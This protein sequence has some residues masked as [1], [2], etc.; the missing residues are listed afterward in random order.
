MA[1]TKRRP[2]FGYVFCDKKLSRKDEVLRIS[3]ATGHHRRWVAMTLLEFWGWV[4]DNF[5]SGVL[6]RHSVAT[7]SLSVD[8]TDA[9][10]WQ[11]VIDVGWL[12]VTPEG[13]EVPGCDVWLGCMAKKRHQDALR[14][15]YKRQG[16]TE[17]GDSGTTKSGLGRDVGAAKKRRRPSK[18]K[19]KRE[20]VSSIEETSLERSRNELWDA[21]CA[22]FGLDPRT[23]G[24]RS[25]V[26]KV[27]RDLG[28][29]GALPAEVAV[30]L[31][32]YRRE[33]PS[34]ADT[35]EA[36]LKHWDRFAKEP[37]DGRRPSEGVGRAGRVEAPPGK[38]A[39]LSAP[40]PVAAPPT[41]FPDG[42]AP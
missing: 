2:L 13:L 37:S 30:R 21:L 17:N 18:T 25:R 5:P 42:Q 20:E 40:P 31:A 24:E 19:T 11:A 7:L 33:W 26:G 10:F 14:A 12:A 3:A 41:L 28:Q 34:A 6:R 29:K 32:R 4:D 16:L 9:H 35:P 23:K 15:W 36:L 8:E 22:A 38:Y 1:K 39:G 27:V